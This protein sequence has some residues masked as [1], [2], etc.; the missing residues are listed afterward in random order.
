[1]AERRLDIILSAEDRFSKI[2]SSANRSVEA[3]GNRLE[4]AATKMVNLKTVSIAATAAL[5]ALGYALYRTVEAANESEASSAK[6]VA[7]LRSTHGAAGMTRQA[8]DD[9]A[10]A[11][12]RKTAYDDD[13]TRSA[14]ALLLTFTRIGKD[15][16]PS[17]LEA[18]LDMSTAMDQ[19]L[20]STVVQVGKALN[21]PI[22]GVTALQ[23]VGVRL[24]ETQKEQVQ[25][26][27]DLNDAASAQK[28]ILS[29][30]ATEFGGAAA[31]QTET[32]GGKLR[33]T[34]NALGDLEKEVGFVITK[35]NFFTKSLDLVRQYVERATTWVTNHRLALM[36]LAKGGMIRV[37]E[38]IG[39]AVE[40]VRFLHNG[41]LGLK[42]VGQAVTLALVDGLR[43]VLE[44]LNLLLWPLKKALDGLMA[45]GLI[46]TNPLAE[47]VDAGR[48]ALDNYR[49]AVLSAGADVL[50]EIEKT[51]RKYDGVRSTIKGIVTEMK[52]WKAEQVDLLDIRVPKGGAVPEIN[53]KSTKAQEA[54]AKH[55]AGLGATPEVLVPGAPEQFSEAAQ[56]E[57]RLQ[58]IQDFHTRKLQLMIDAGKTEEELTA[59]FNQAKL[60]SDR[61]TNQLRLAQA[62]GA[63]GMMSN[64][65][66]N[67]TV[68]T[69]KEG[70]AAFKAMKAFAIA[71]TTIQTY[72]AAQGAY[73]A[74]APIPIVG[75]ALATAAAAAA[76][77]A[78]LARVKQIEGMEPGGAATGSTISAGGTANPA[79]SGGS[80]S[81]YPVPQRTDSGEKV[82]NVTIQI[83]NPMGNEDWDRLAEENIA[84]A[85][86]RALG[87]NVSIS[88][89]YLGEDKVLLADAVRLGGLNAHRHVHGKRL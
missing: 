68:V 38:A 41:W 25:S 32:F 52:S 35:N 4:K 78:G 46:K 10:D 53:G 7:V 30:L 13:A 72:R 70:G 29:E 31:A 69:G 75:P 84:P 88:N 57:K 76:I 74:L 48:E 86:R 79:Y 83:Y 14:E 73:A 80:P 50:T 22:L 43:L 58:A 23:R 24:T 27:M 54:A 87:R 44:S 67:L 26:F 40:A 42:L 33:Q 45:F 60:D 17:A 62:Q 81:A 47:A 34:G 51:N 77:V 20:K 12:Q 56:M 6:L 19:D 39:Y 63:F 36:E 89:G 37:V 55:L 11:M 64:M 21:D 1:M 61:Q 16:F 18:V 66:Q 65:M 71:E 2:L 3:F 5:G 49:D 59:A 28:I 9:L 85:L 8:L 15:V 82:P